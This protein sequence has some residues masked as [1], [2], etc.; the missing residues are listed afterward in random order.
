MS[1]APILT[2]LQVA[3]YLQEIHETAAAARWTLNE[4][5]LSATRRTEATA[6]AERELVAADPDGARMAEAWVAQNMEHQH[7]FHGLEAFLA[8]WS[9][10]SLLV[11]P[12]GRSGSFAQR[13]GALLREVLELTPVD[14]AALGDRE[15]RDAW[16][17]FDERLDAAMHGE[18]LLPERHR[19]TV[20]SAR[21]PSDRSL[22]VI[23]I[24]T[25]C[26]HYPTRDRSRRT[27]ELRPLA[28]VLDRLGGALAHA[29]RRY[30]E[31]YPYRAPGPW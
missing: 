18:T 17:H 20:S 10:V 5:E 3:V 25:L 14:A 4:L 11:F 6:R 28:G 9:R 15:L 7:L 1:D 30:A 21:P 31:R 12:T 29:P 19:F 27:T 13:R 24:D 2:G 26:V 8:A 16:M 22:R 23:E